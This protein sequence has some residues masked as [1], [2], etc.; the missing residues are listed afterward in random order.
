MVS[1]EGDYKYAV[2]RPVPLTA[3]VSQ[4]EYECLQIEIKMSPIQ[5][6]FH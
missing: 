3:T 4:I 1:V 2:D 6:H 5:I